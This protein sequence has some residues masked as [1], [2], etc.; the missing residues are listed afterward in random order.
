MAKKRVSLR[1]AID[2]MCKQCIYDKNA[3]GTWKKQIE[4]CTA[5]DCAL[6]PVRPKSAYGKGGQ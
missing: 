1:G 5:T 3:A 2:S 4:D 6:Y